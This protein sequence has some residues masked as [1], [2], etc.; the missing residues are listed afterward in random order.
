MSPWNVALV[1]LISGIF[2]LR[3][4]GTMC[5]LWGCHGMCRYNPGVCKYKPGMCKYKTVMCK[6]KPGMCIYKPGMCTNMPHCSDKQ[7]SK[8]QSWKRQNYK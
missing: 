6:Y 5:L 2:F 7:S 4:Y 8:S 1:F 3:G